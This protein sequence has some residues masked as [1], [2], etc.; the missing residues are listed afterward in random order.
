MKMHEHDQDIIMALAEGSLDPAAAA[1]AEAAIAD[2]AECRRDLELQRVALAALDDAPPVYLTA[3]ESSQLHDRLHKQLGTGLQRAQPAPSL[4]P[5][6]RWVGA[7]LGS[8]AV[9]LAV[10]L[11]L[12]TMLGGSDDDTADTTAFESAAEE[13]G[14]AADGAT[15]TTAGPEVAAAPPLAA[16][17]SRDSLGVD[18]DTTAA[19]ETTTTAP[20]SEAL[21]DD[22]ANFLAYTVVGE[23]DDELRNDI[24]DRL[25]ADEGVFLESDLAAKRIEPE[26]HACVA[27]L[28]AAETASGEVI[29]QIVGVVVD[30]L[31]Q[32]RP[33]V[34][35]VNAEE[36]AETTLVSITL[37]ECEIFQTFP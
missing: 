18:A 27:A 3:T 14:G 4:R 23:L 35:L 30:E 31:G 11:L 16:E 24:V 10:F 19:A 37:P 26:W 17:D 7:A 20:S 29:P 34:A 22:F 1:A 32:E 2:C 36:A 25:S 5:W 28:F 12:P 13:L 33:L 15:E 6:G 9:L 21:E 8:A